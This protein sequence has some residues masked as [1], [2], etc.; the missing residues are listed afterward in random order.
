ML[1][2]VARRKA[3]FD[4]AKA[5][6]ARATEAWQKYALLENLRDWVATYLGNGGKLRHEPLLK[7]APRK[8]ETLRQ[9]VDRVRTEIEQIEAEWHVAEQAPMPPAELKAEIAATVDA[10]A[11]KGTPT[12]DSRARGGDPAGVNQKIRLDFIR[13]HK[14]GDGGADFFVW[15][16]RD[17]LVDRLCGMVDE[18]DL[19]SALSD[20]ARDARFTDLSDRR[21]DLERQE[22]ALICA[23]AAEGLRIDRRLDTD[24]RAVLQVAEAFDDEDLPL[25]A[26]DGAYPEDEGDDVADNRAARRARYGAR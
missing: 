13:E 14:V 16:M 6:E 22:E 1:T 11:A 15:L 20:D 5:V 18:L 12:I 9:S 23:A 24:P 21:L 17:A 25:E 2:P 7:A 26:I 4:R 3:E 10:I 19:T 8:G